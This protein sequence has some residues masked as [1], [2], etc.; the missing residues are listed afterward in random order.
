M[1]IVTG[2]TQVEANF[3]SVLTQPQIK[4][5]GTEILTTEGNCSNSSSRVILNYTDT[6]IPQIPSE[7]TITVQ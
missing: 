3:N 7:S 6:A 1:L 5:F 4:L 2:G